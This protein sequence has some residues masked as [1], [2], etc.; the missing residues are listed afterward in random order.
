MPSGL[1]NERGLSF[2]QLREMLRRVLEQLDH[3]RADVLV[4]EVMLQRGER[5]K[6]RACHHVDAV[7]RSAQADEGRVHFPFGGRVEERKLGALLDV[8]A[9]VHQQILGIEDHVRVAGVIERGQL[10]DL[11]VFVHVDL[12]GE[13]IGFVHHLLSGDRAN[14]LSLFIRLFRHQTSKLVLGLDGKRV[15]HSGHD[16]FLSVYMNVDDVCVVVCNIYTSS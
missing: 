8:L 4:E 6:A 2:R 14:D 12:H 10:A 1:L 15:H 5:Q 9:G 11:R 3:A 13:A 16:Q 7:S